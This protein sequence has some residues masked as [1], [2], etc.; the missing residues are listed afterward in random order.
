[1]DVWILE[2]AQAVAVK[3]ADI[4]TALIQRK[5]DARLGLATG[6]T[7]QA[8]YAELAR[9]NQ[10]GDLS[11]SRVETFNLDEY[12][13]VGPQHPQSFH[14]AMREKLFAKVDVDP[15]NTHLPAGDTADPVAEAAAYEALI[16][17]RG[18]IDL[19]ILGIGRNGH[20]GFNEPGSSL[21]SRTRVKTLSPATLRD[22]RLGKPDLE[23][24]TMA[25]TMGI[26]TILDARALLVLATGAAKARAVAAALE[27]PL[28]ASCPASAIQ[29]HPHATVLLDPEAAAD[30]R[31]TDYYE[32]VDHARRLLAERSR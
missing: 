16:Q 10:L 15:A 17:A 24:P 8:L 14:L 28:A 1:M 32:L 18:G 29:L 12:L 20:I 26:A 11:F 22:N 7:P 9:R 31:L 30:L 25:I 5:P 23:A 6:A 19:Q 2:S 13:G 27:G 3:A 4:C 21:G